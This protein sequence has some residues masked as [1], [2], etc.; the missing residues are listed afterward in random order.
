MELSTKQK[1]FLRSKAH[2]LK[3]LAQVGKNGVT[4]GFIKSTS[5]LLGQH[6]LLKIKF[7]EFKE[8]RKELFRSLVDQVDGHVIGMVGNTGIVFKPHPKPAKRQY[9]LPE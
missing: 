4:P 9:I 6:E 5:E 2:H 3:P 7:N 8:E 1:C